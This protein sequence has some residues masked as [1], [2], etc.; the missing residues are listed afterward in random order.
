M[1]WTGHPL[2]ISICSRSHNC[3]YDYQVVGSSL[4]AILSSKFSIHQI[5]LISSFSIAFN[6]P[7]L[8]KAVS[9]C[10]QSQ[11]TY[12]QILV[13]LSFQKTSDF[14]ISLRSKVLAGAQ[15]YKTLFGLTS[16]YLDFLSKKAS[17][18]TNSNLIKI[19]NRHF[20]SGRT[21]YKN[22]TEYT[23]TWSN[24]FWGFLKHFQR[25]RSLEGSTFT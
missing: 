21:S 10:W 7:S 12:P 15:S 19:S 23:N 8:T 22:L 13:F 20:N 18:K 1:T 4:E 3:A 2:G 24:N 9:F 14:S 5:C 11:P 25:W 17:G 16:E 6:S